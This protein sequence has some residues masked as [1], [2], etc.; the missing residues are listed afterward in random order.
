MLRLCLVLICLATSLS[1]QQRS[2]D[3]PGNFDYYVMALSWSPNWC[4]YEGD[5]RGSPQCDTAADFGWVLH[6]LWP[7][8]ERGWPANCRHAFRN[9]SSRDTADMADL[10]GSAGSAWHQ[11]NKHGACSGLS[12]DDYYA[13]AREAYGRII[14]PEVLRNL[15]RDVTLPASLIEQ[16]FMRD[17]VDLDADEITI[18]C[19]S[20]MIQEARICLTRDLELRT[21]GADVLRDCTL[22]DALFQA[23]R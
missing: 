5:A 22:E 8:N 7:Q 12:P 23:I 6:G 21:C 13:L 9:P 2:N 3:T 14:R 17:N 1:A 20:G 11:W 4:R 16:A 18:T 19:Q 15:D 10:F